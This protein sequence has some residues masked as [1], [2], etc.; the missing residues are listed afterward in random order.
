MTQPIIDDLIRRVKAGDKES[1]WQLAEPHYKSILLT[2]YSL[3]RNVDEA[4]EVAQET[5]LKALKNFDQLKDRERFRSWL[6][7]IAI[8]E[9][10]QKIRK[11][12]PEVQAMDDSA[13]DDREFVPRDFADWRDIPSDELEKKEFWD[14]V[15]SALESLSPICREVFILRDIQ[16]FTISEIAST[17]DILEANVSLRLHRAR[18]QMRELLAPLFRDPVS[19]WI[20]LVLMADMPAMMLHRVVRCKTAIRELSKYIDSE[21]DPDMREKIE[22]HLKYCRRCKIL[23]NNTRKLLYIVADERVFL[24]PFTSTHTDWREFQ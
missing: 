12:H 20:P 4:A 22:R 13:R 21:L 23:L 5:M 7:S 2:A 16:Q 10:R 6:M 17:L 24:P 19:P 14:A 18:M 11:R 9:A 15:H 1:F 3:L 8:N